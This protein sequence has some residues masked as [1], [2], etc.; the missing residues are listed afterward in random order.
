MTKD[1][2]HIDKNG[3]PSMVDVGEKMPTKR[4]AKARSIVVL[5]EEILQHL[6]DGEIKTKKGV[7]SKR[8]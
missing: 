2:T 1:F 8:R 6:E 7:C 4:M 3:N 5:D